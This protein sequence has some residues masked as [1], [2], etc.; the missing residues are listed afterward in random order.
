MELHGRRT[1]RTDATEITRENVLA[2]LQQA[3]ITHLLNRQ[4]EQYLFDYYRGKQEIRNK[5]KE[6]RPEINHIITEN[7]AYAITDFKT[8]YIC[9]D[10]IVYTSRSQSKANGDKINR[11]NEY[12]LF[13][14]KESS[15]KELFDWMHIT[16]HGYRL[17]LGGETKEQPFS[18]TVLQP[19]NTFVVYANTPG[20]KPLMG[21]YY[22]TDLMS[23]ENTF[24]VYTKD[25]FYL[26]KGVFASTIEEEKRSRKPRNR[27]ISEEK[28]I[29]NGIPIV[30]YRLNEAMLG[31]FEPVISLLDCI[32]YVDSDR[33][34]G[35]TT[36]VNSLCV[37]Y[38]AELPEGED[39]NTIREK[40]LITLKSIG[41][42]KADIK[43]LSE[44]LDQTSTQNFKDDLYQSVLQIV[45]MPN[46]SGGGSDSS[47]NGAMFLKQGYQLA[48]TRAKDTEL[49]FKKSERECLKLVLNLCEGAGLTIPLSDVDITFTRRAYSDIVSKS[50]VLIS[51]LNNEKVAPIDAW[52]LSGITPDPDE[53]CRR[54]LEY[55]DKNKVATP[56]R[57]IEQPT[58]ETVG[59]GEAE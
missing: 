6:V 19:M 31:A 33:A 9:G 16:G 11:L 30:E 27:R 24:S 40:G 1:I 28:E 52:T 14:N 18:L 29:Y 7:R 21:V 23:G 39:G 22:V 41:E 20:L 26:I 34:D 17:V 47:N 43:I 4:E 12:M 42:N 59:N 56:D 13:E 36:F 51:M 25:T 49:M 2:V 55:Y 37:L 45:G 5:V 54:G 50:T 44:Q 35:L 58:N 10:P 46:Q 48:E 3:Y 38:N 32:N 57:R 53:A 8:G 15:D